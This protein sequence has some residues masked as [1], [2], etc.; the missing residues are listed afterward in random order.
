LIEI[1]WLLGLPDGSVKYAARMAEAFMAAVELLRGKLRKAS[2]A[3][4]RPNLL[5]VLLARE[6]ANGSH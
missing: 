4:A 5:K 3:K 2:A 6:L 1:D